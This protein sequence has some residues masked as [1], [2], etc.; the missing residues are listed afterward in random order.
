[1]GTIKDVIDEMREQGHSI[2]AVSICSF[3]PFPSRELHDVLAQAK[4]MV[5]LEKSLAVGIG[6]IVSHNLRMAVSGIALHAYTVIAGLG[7]RAIT[8]ASL[9][10]LF[11]KALKDELEPLTFLDLNHDMVNR[12][13]ER[14]KQLRRSGPTAENILRGLGTVAATLR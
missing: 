5:V 4:R 1:M 7:G 8:K 11:E 3:R 14:E 9:H 10:A 13:L 6:G 12:E 2:G